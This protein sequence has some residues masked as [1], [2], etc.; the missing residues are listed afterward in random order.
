MSKNKN[1]LN[2]TV[3]NLQQVA[4]QLGIMLMAAATVT[5]MLELPD[6]A[7][8]RIVLPG[9]PSFVL[10]T[11]NEELNNPVRREREETGPHYISYSVSQRTP[12]RSGAGAR[13]RSRQAIIRNV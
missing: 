13:P 7:N 5:G 9:Q 6:R 1:V 4:A 3:E 12:A 2:N 10:A 11:E 8:S